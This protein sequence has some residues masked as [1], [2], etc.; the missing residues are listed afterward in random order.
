MTDPRAGKA[1]VGLALIIAL[2]ALAWT[3]AVEADPCP[4]TCIPPVTRR[5]WVN[6][7]LRNTN[8]V[9]R[10]EARRIWRQPTL[11]R[12]VPYTARVGH[13]GEPWNSP[14]A[15]DGAVEGCHVSVSKTEYG[16]GI[17]FLGGLPRFY[18]D[19][20]YKYTLHRTWNYDGWRVFPQQEWDDD[21][22]GPFANLRW[23]FDGAHDIEDVYFQVGG[24]QF[25]THRHSRKGRFSS[26]PKLG[27]A[28][29]DIERSIL[30]KWHGGW[31]AGGHSATF[32]GDN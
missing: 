8:G 9:T 4:T 1:L 30:A 20:L 29:S 27:G 28:V 22:I 3:S 21:W 24:S 32:C 25:A 11:R 15:V 16:Y 31:E 23:N 18:R 26:V 17:I 14:A 6:G 7:V 2:T 12:S 13:H 10:A 19:P 5:Q